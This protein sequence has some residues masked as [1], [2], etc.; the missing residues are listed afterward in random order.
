MASTARSH[1][2]A[3]SNDVG[4]C[5]GKRVGIRFPD[6]YPS[7]HFLPHP[8]SKGGPGQSRGRQAGSPRPRRQRGRTLSDLRVC[9]SGQSGRLRLRHPS[10]MRFSRRGSGVS[11]PKVY[12]PRRGYRRGDRCPRGVPASSCE[13]A[14]EAMPTLFLP[15]KGRYGLHDYEKTF[16]ADIKGGKG[17]CR[18]S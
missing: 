10:V 9:R 13:L 15:R 18:S 11:R 12:A 6:L 17:A 5:H 2:R 7:T 3:F 4:E 1:A 8:R 14:I 16:C